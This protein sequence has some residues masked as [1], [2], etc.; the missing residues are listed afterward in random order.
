MADDLK[1]QQDLLAKLSEQYSL[2]RLKGSPD[3]SRV[4]K[5]G[6]TRLRGGIRRRSGT[7]IMY[8]AGS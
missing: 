4:K 7:S 1:T 8:R 6:G 5:Y 2:E 3:D